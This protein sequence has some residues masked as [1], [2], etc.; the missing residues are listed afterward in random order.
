M[1][2]HKEWLSFA[3]DDLKAAKLM[4]FNEEIILGPALYHTQQCAEKAIKAFLIYK[5]KPLRRIHDLVELVH[6]CIELDG[7]FE[8]ILMDA[9]DLNPYA[10][11]ARYPDSYYIMPDVTTAHV[12]FNQAKKIFEF[13]KTKTQL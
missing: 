8:E 6:L 11:R 5:D 7:D 3:E 9:A 12:N 13:V 4:L 1:Q 2:R 10:T